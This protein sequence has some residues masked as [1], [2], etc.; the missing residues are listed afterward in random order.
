M[1]LEKL[2][3]NSGN[4]LELNGNQQ[5]ARVT[6]VFR[7]KFKINNGE[8]EL[9]ADL[10][11]NMIHE[12]LFPAVGD[13]VITDNE[14]LIIDI[15]ERKSKISRQVAGRKIDEQVIAANI[16][17]VFIVSSLNQDFNL[18]RMERYLTMVWESGANPIFLLTKADIAEEMDVKLEELEAIA[19][20]V[21]IHIIS[22]FEGSGLEE[23]NEY[24][25]NNKTSIFIGS[26]G[27][28]KSTLINK[29][30][31]EEVLATKEIRDDDAK[32][33][34][35][36]THREMFF[37]EDS[38]IIIDTP[39]MREIQLWSGDVES[40]FEDIEDLALNC[41][42]RDCTHESEPGCAVREAIETGELGEKR[43]E[44]YKKLKKELAYDGLSHKQLEKKKLE[45]MI[46]GSG[47]FGEA[48]GVLKSAKKKSKMKN[49]NRR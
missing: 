13:W 16:D 29:L 23:L 40:T 37:L 4:R 43:Y 31:G 26:S 9:L 21:P 34:H 18:S 45:N 39:G 14:H 32:G 20:G 7:N 44:N 25:N 49:K 17:N 22:S 30:L 11:G 36:T 27:V 10:K 5:L 19:F 33:R 8:T 6:A 42:F 24:F 12:G 3:W 47:S 35:T 15:L 48:A 1:T 38:G 41:K 46:S 2:G 28:G